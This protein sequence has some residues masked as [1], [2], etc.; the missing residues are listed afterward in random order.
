MRPFSDFTLNMQQ[1]A[2]I[3]APNCYNTFNLANHNKFMKFQ[4]NAAVQILNGRPQP[5][6]GLPIG[7]FHPVFDRFREL[8]DSTKFDATREQL[9]STLSLIQASQDLYALEG[10]EKGRTTAILPLLNS[11]LDCSISATDIPRNDCKS[12]GTVQTRNGA[13]V[14]VV[15]VKNEIGT[16]ETDPS[17]RGAIAYAKYW[18]QVSLIHSLPL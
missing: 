17:V 12:D 7:L 2:V 6:A 1:T 5:A 3:K 8:V 13:Y 11:I 10:G 14:L 18:G 16:G 15:E 4:Q 9:S